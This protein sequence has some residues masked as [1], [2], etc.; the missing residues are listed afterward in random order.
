MNFG[1]RHQK[2]RGHAPADTQQV[3]SP[4][5]AEPEPN[6]P[7]KGETGDGWE[8][9]REERVGGV[10]EAV[11]VVIGSL[12]LPSCTRHLWPETHHLR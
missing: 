4:E 1:V 3:P 6:G 9:G 5:D 8:L 7:W 10:G 2:A 12:D 11:K